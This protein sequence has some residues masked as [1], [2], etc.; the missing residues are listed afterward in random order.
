[1]FPLGQQTAKNE[2]IPGIRNTRQAKMATILVVARLQAKLLGVPRV[3]G[4]MPV[5]PVV[6]GRGDIQVGYGFTLFLYVGKQ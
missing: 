5:G 1:M 6:G 3:Q 4:P 2:F